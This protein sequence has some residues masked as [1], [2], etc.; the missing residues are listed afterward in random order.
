MSLSLFHRA[1]ALTSFS[2][3]NLFVPLPINFDLNLTSVH[4]AQTH[5]T[6]NQIPQQIAS[7]A[8]I[9]KFSNYS[10]VWFME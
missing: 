5:F 8:F 1:R 4:R 6:N 7:S 2:S 3:I 10:K 9:F